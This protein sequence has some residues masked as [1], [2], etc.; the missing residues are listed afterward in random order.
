MHVATMSAVDSK[1]IGLVGGTSGNE[2]SKQ[3]GSNAVSVGLGSGAASTALVILSSGSNTHL[4]NGSQDGERPD[5]FCS[6]KC[7]AAMPS[8]C[9]SDEHLCTISATV[10]RNIANRLPALCDWIK[11][12]L[13]CHSVVMMGKQMWAFSTNGE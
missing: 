7:G 11:V 9:F 10:D 6:N 2:A 13:S 12:I 3:A 1:G 4:T 5:Q 8:Q